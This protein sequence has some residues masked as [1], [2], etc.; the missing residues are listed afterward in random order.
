MG[1]RLTPR[2]FEIVA[3]IHKSSDL[4]LQRVKN[5]QKEDFMERR[6]TIRL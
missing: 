3:G 4:K 2:Q 6:E 1:E 5:A